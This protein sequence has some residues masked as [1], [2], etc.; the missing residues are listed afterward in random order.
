MSS[1][2]LVRML[3]VGVS[4]N[5]KTGNIPQ[6]YVGESKE[7]NR[8]SCE[9]CPLLDDGCYHHQ[10]TG[11]MA[12]SS[13]IRA[14][15]KNPARYELKTALKKAVR[16]ARY[17]RGAVGGDPAAL[18]REQ[19]DGYIS[20]LR[21]AGLKG[22]LLYTHFWEGRG[23]HLKGVAMASCDTLE[24]ADRAVDAGW[25]AA[26]IL[27]ASLPSSGRNRLKTPAWEGE[28]FT[29]PSGRRVVVCPAQRPELRKDCNTCGLCDPTKHERV[30]VI[31]FLEH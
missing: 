21:S 6:G 26:V 15:K 29:T 17:A 28:K 12:H 3:W 10:G 9:G 31:G 5:I 11:R 18:T 20:T 22:L 19:V 4:G 24:Q 27:P 1:L 7:E 2:A 25:R 13:M 8:A 23:A 30:P 14:N 16:T